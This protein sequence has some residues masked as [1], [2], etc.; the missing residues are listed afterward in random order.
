MKTLFYL[1][2]VALIIGWVLGAF[3]YSADI[4]IHILLVMAIFSI[5]LGT[6]SGKEAL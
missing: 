5:V 6:I 4:L 1:I 2:A 3:L